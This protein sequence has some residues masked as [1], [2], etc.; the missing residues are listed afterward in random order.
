[1]VDYN[2]VVVNTQL[3]YKMVKKGKVRD[4]YEIDA[5][6]L[7]IISTDRISAF[8][9]V[10]QNPIPQKGIFLNKI[11]KFMMEFIERKLGIKVHLA[12]EEV[13]NLPFNISQR[14]VVVKKATPIK[15]ECIVRGYLVGSLYN[16]YKQYKTINNQKV[17][18]T[19]KFG[20]QLPQILFT[21]TTKEDEGHDKPITIDN[22]KALYGE[23]ITNFIVEN[24]LRIYQEAKSYL[25]TKKLVLVDTKLEWGIIGNDIV[26]I[27]EVVTPDSSRYWLEEDYKKGEVAEFYD[28]QLVRDY[29][30]KIGW[31]K[32]P[33]APLLPQDIIFETARR[34]ELIYQRI[35]N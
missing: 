29:L 4:I 16:E 13:N 17:N 1:M 19:L 8:D 30:L 33:P 9:V 35:T 5:D 2:D 15:V 32:M 6:K 14:S 26:L 20:D 25:L 18:G 27:D 3:P 10:L 24:S 34:Y 7:L 11:S 21:P 23:K 22:I 28:K 31:N 12:E